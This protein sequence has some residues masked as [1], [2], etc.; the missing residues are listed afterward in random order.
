MQKLERVINNQ[1]IKPHFSKDIRFEFQPGISENQKTSISQRVVAE[2]NANLI[3]RND[4][5]RQ[6]GY[7][8]ADEDGYKDDLV[9]EPEGGGGLDEMMGAEKEDYD[10]ECIECGY[11][12]LGS[13]EH[14]DE[15]GCPECGGQ[16][17]AIERPGAG[18]K[19]SK[20]N[21]ESLRETEDWQDF[22]YQPSDVEDLKE[23]ITPQVREAFEKILEDDRVDD[24]IER[25]ANGEEEK[26][27]IELHG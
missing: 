9:E 27:S 3:E 24:V 13:E 6:L 11:E 2:F 22:S 20:K 4:A 23:E 5:R 10:C 14:C 25:L 8:K 1:I 15:I 7:E 21:D 19:D 12:V 18:R 26:S 17:R 16:M